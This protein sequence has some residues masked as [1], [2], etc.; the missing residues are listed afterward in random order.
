VD[1]I[2]VVGASLA[3]VHAVDAL[4][5]HDYAGEIV[6]VGEEP[7]LPYD[8]PPLSKEGLR[9]LPE[10]DLLRPPEWYEESRV[11]L[12]L[13]RAAGR[14][15]TADRTVLLTDGTAVPYDG[16]VIATGSRVRTL[17]CGDEHIR[18]LR[19]VDDGARLHKQLS[20]NEHVAVLGG[21]FI[22]LEVAA[23]LTEM[24]CAVTVVEVA[25]VP[26]AR[27]LGDQVGE[28][29][30]RLHARHGVDVRC[31][32]PAVGVTADGAGFSVAVGGGEPVH[33]DL[34]VGALGAEP[35]TDW[36][37][38]SGVD[39]ADGVRCD[40][41][42]RTGSSDVVAAGDVARWYNPLFDEDMRIEQW[43]NA[44]EQGR[45]A[46]LTLLGRDEAYASVPY[47]WSDQF[48]A[49]MRFVGRT[50]GAAQVRVDAMTENS[51]QVVFGRGNTCVGALCVNAT[52]HLPA[53]RAAI[54]A[55]EDYESVVG[56]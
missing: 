12:M 56:T 28:W 27:V 22:G 36:L 45:H 44:V 43:V 29:F 10:P 47:F 9:H 24:G 17:G 41:A 42:L 34:V 30:H 3:A 13:G 32:R 1:R 33:A 25:P 8:R 46:A 37:R 38:G 18:Y 20:G 35:V 53:Y 49:K 15:D 7:H 6:L 23:T 2:V 40:R 21:G 19:T 4:R 51:L 31:G 48:D 16:L 39:L 26:L 54:A 14:L 50:N 11:T 5:S 52:A 55:G